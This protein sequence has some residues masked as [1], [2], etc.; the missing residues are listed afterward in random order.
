MISMTMMRTQ[1][2][3]MRT[4]KGMMIT[5]ATTILPDDDD[6]AGPLGWGVGRISQV[7]A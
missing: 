3:M 5:T 7:F 6:G 4:H 2:G 1:K